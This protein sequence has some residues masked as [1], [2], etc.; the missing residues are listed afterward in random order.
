MASRTSEHLRH[1]NPELLN[2]MQY[3]QH[4]PK[5]LFSIIRRTK[6]SE[7]EPTDPFF[8]AFPAFR[9]PSC[10]CARPLSAHSPPEHAPRPPAADLTASSPSTLNSEPSTNLNMPPFLPRGVGHWLSNTAYVK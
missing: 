5:K 3:T 9:S 4:S 2:P 10:F 7:G 1:L 6:A 8:G